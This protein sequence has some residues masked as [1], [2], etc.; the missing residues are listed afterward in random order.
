[1]VRTHAEDDYDRKLLADVE[2]HGWHLVGIGDDPDGPGY[3]FSVG[4]YHTL[5]QPEVC[6]FG[7]SNSSVMG[8]IIN[9]VGALMKSGKHFEDW[10]ESPDVLEGYSCMF[11]RVDPKLYR[12]YFGYALWF[13][14]GENFPMLQC[15]WPDQDHRYPWDSQFDAQ[16]VASQPVLAVKDAWPFKEGKNRAVFTTRPVIEEGHPV[17]LVS[18][19]DEDWQFLCGSTNDSA[20]A[21]LVSLGSIVEAHPTVTELADLPVGWQATREAPGQPWRRTGCPG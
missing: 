9:G 18:H 15:V 14:E 19:D 16:M 6:I 5:G 11:R 21:R 17:L 12:E 1:M 7:L 10:Y 3:V 8:H 2:S 20:D 4:I 13:Y